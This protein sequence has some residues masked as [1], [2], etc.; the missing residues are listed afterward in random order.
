[1]PPTRTEGKDPIYG[2]VHVND[3]ANPVLINNDYLTAQAVFRVKGFRGWTPVDERTGQAKEPI[4]HSPYF[5]GHRR[6]FS[7]QVSM[8]FKHT[9]SGDDI[10]FGTFFDKPLSL[11]S[12]W[13]IPWKIAKQIDP[14]MDGE[15]GIDKPFI[16]SPLICAVNT[17]HLEPFWRQRPS[18]LTDARRMVSM[19]E[20]NYKQLNGTSFVERNPPGKDP[21][22]DHRMISE[23]LPL[24][25]WQWAGEKG[26]Q[27]EENI[28]SNHHHWYT[29]PHRSDFYDNK[30][31]NN[32]LDH[33]TSRSELDAAAR[34][35]W[36]LK[37][38]HR[39]RFIFHPDTVYTFDFANHVVDLNDMTLNLGFSLNVRPYLGDQPV[40]YQCKT[41]D[42]SVTFFTL[43][44]SIK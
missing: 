26:A 4:N 39:R 37:E 8:R 27:M 3:D 18:S 17:F 14:S 34:R 2:A 9:W 15:L 25:P 19:Y 36:F 28:L 31:R 24:P 20:P 35:K 21:R 40:K 42:G 5:D 11:P 41:R 7:M 10:M 16:C 12:L 32:S 23:A 30:G 38:E 43:E 44:F 22:D 13:R 29:V 6:T 1:M 33:L